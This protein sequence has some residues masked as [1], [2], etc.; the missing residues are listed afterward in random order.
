DGLDEVAVEARRHGPR[1]VVLLGPARQGHEGD[2][3]Q[4]L[5]APERP[6]DVVT[7]LV[8]QADVEEDDRRTELSRRGEG[9]AAVV[10]QA[11][12]VALELQEQ[13]EP[14]G[15]V[16]VVLDHED[17]LRLRPRR[18][19]ARRGRRWRL[20]GNREQD[21][22]LRALAGAAALRLDL[23]AVQLNEA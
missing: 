20:A 21:A 5:L 1:A 18:L 11:D 7:A 23:P 10:G 12:L 4:A 19:G 16:R 13:D 6:C 9:L 15:G 14:F 22:E 17:A 8:G 2:A 3:L